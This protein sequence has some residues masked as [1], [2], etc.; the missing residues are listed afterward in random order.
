MT[1]TKLA[2]A[3]ALSSLFAGA[4][5]AAP[6]SYSVARTIGSG[7][8]NGTITT[9]GTFGVLSTGNITGWSLTLDDGTNSLLINDGNS[10]VLVYGSLLSADFDSIDFDFAGVGGG[11]LFQNPDIGS[12][13]NYWCLEGLNANCTG[14]GQGEHVMLTAANWTVGHTTEQVIGTAGGQIPEPASL[15]L[16]GAALAGLALMR[17]RA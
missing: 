8:V 2:A 17:R 14:A 6:I 5:S 10:N 12:S 9:D 1:F 16:V 7:S 4:V 15:A 13:R 3:L 11:A